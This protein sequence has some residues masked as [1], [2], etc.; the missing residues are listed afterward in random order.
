MGGSLC[1]AGARGLMME[2][3]MA[4]L[5]FGLEFTFSMCAGS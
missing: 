4:G 2:A 1:P 5:L 3:V